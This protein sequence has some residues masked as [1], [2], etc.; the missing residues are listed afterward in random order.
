MGCCKSKSSVVEPLRYKVFADRELDIERDS[1]EQSKRCYLI[2][3]NPHSGPGKSLQVFRRILEPKLKAAG[4]SY[5]LVITERANHARAMM[6]T[7]NL[8]EFSAIVILSGDGL[9]F[10]VVNGMF[11]RPDRDKALR[12]PLGV[13]PSGSGNAL[14]AS[15][16]RHCNIPIDKK[17]FIE[18]SC[19][20]IASPHLSVLPVN[21]F[22]V[23]T[24]TEHFAGFLSVGWA[25]M[26][27]IDIE[28]E[29]WRKALG[30][31]RF[32]AGA[33][34]RCF[35]L[36]TYK[37]RVSYLP[38]NAKKAIPESSTSPNDVS[39]TKSTQQSTTVI[40]DDE[41]SVRAKTSET[42]D[43]GAAWRKRYPEEGEFPSLS[44]PVP[45]SWTVMNEDF[46]LIHAITMS[47]IGSDGPYMPCAQLD[48]DRIYLTYVTKRELSNRVSML[49]CLADIE[50]SKHLNYDFLK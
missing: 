30:H 23:E 36:R 41:N 11:E 12:K 3:V 45:S 50:T 15:V 43:W 27:D 40:V 26:S 46:V 34:V 39:L 14:I 24:P 47:H 2:F 6:R 22:H 16:F 4:I 20:M 44:D 33:V 32:T 7:R 8:D 19:E 25:L 29:K 9:V 17:S 5:E 49:K 13:V 31:A 42:T 28:S 18:R 1:M 37:G 35:H 10:E 48:D 38:A 21:L